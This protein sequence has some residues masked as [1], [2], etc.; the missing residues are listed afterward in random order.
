MPYRELDFNLSGEALAMQKEVRN[1]QHF[2]RERRDF[3]RRQ[4]YARLV[5]WV[6]RLASWKSK[7]HPSLSQLLDY[8]TQI[9]EHSEAIELKGWLLNAIRNLKEFGE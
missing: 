4:S 1:F 7:N 5:K 9:K 8:E 2:L 6:Q 3:S